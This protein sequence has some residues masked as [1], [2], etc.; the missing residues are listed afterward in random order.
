MMESA[1]VANA[2]D[3]LAKLDRDLREDD[4]LGDAGLGCVA[5]DFAWASR[6]FVKL[7]VERGEL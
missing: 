3:V 4:A 7:R 6:D 2:L 5:A 1:G